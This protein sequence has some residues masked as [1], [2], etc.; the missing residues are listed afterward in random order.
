MMNA[1]SIYATPSNLDRMTSALAQAM[2]EF[3][4]G[5]WIP[6]ALVGAIGIVFWCIGHALESQGWA[7]LY[8]IGGQAALDGYFA[9]VHAAKLTTW[10]RM[11]GALSGRSVSIGGVWQGIGMFILFVIVPASTVLCLM[12]AGIAAFLKS[13]IQTRRR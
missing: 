4:N 5:M 1:K 8:Q 2:S 10:E 7:E 3:S 6:F 11:A 9:T 12:G 13:G